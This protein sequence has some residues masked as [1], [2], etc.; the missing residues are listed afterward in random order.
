MTTEKR[1]GFTF[2]LSLLF[3]II[4]A[5]LTYSDNVMQ[6]GLGWFICISEALQYGLIIMY[7][8]GKILNV[9]KGELW[10][11]IL[12]GS[13]MVAIITAMLLNS[14]V[15][16][17]DIAIAGWCAWDVNLVVKRYGMIAKLEGK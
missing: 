2:L 4:G 13:E 10:Y 17:I 12:Y 3:I 6:Q 5:M 11:S 1:R 16:I 14:P 9:K 8:K 7:E 15:G